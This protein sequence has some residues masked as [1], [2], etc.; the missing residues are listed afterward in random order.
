MKPKN[1]F[2]LCLI[3]STAFLLHSC[4]CE[5][6]KGKEEAGYRQLG[7]EVP[8]DTQE[9][10]SNGSAGTLPAA[11]S[12][13]VARHPVLVK[14]HLF[15]WHKKKYAVRFYPN[16]FVGPSG[17]LMPDRKADTINGIRVERLMPALWAR[18]K[19]IVQASPW[20]NTYYVP[21]DSVLSWY[22][23]EIIQG[24]LVYLEGIG[25][26]LLER[27]IVVYFKESP[28]NEEVDHLVKTYKLYPFGSE[29]INVENYQGSYFMSVAMADPR[30]AHLL[31]T[32]HRIAKEPFVD[33]VQNNVYTGE[34]VGY[35]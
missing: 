35:D 27:H 25:S 15:I 28:K 3:A 21:N 11:D 29:N 34:P 1:V 2:T 6:P 5:D 31:N 16:A 7:V 22:R 19:F 9:T 32:C 20:L 12:P 8:V 24:Q 26:C 14:N 23:K 10:L 33:W 13:A 30:A 18:H 17:E 4:A